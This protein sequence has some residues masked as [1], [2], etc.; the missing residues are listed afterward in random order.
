MV[1]ETKSEALRRRVRGRE[2]FVNFADGAVYEEEVVGGDVER[3]RD[4]GVSGAEE[5][6]CAFDYKRVNKGLATLEATLQITMMVLYVY[7]WLAYLILAR[8]TG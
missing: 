4:C 3:V 5:V 7:V 1:G 6:L 8:L 2:G